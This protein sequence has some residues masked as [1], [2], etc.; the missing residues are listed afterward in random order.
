MVL[1]FARGWVLQLQFQPQ[2]PVFQIVLSR[3]MFKGVS[4]LL[5][6]QK[7]FKSSRSFTKAGKL[8]PWLRQNV[9]ALSFFSRTQPKAKRQLMRLHWLSA[10]GSRER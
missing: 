10:R 8:I 1:A 7:L 2:I 9:G 5:H 4:W 3:N 6:K